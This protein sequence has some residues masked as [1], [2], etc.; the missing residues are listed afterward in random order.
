MNL[1][2]Y[3]PEDRV[4]FLRPYLLKTSIVGLDGDATMLKLKLEQR[5]FYMPT[6][7][8]DYRDFIEDAEVF[9]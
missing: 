6:D 7:N 5:Y 3:L 9:M 2:S 8:V 4:H 1:E